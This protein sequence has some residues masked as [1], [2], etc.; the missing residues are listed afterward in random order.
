MKNMNKTKDKN[1]NKIKVEE[2][3]I[4]GITYVP[5]SEYK[6]ANKNND[7]LDFVCIRTYSAGVHCGYLESRDKKEVVLRDAIRI[8]EWKGAFTLSQLSM[9]GVSKPDGCKFSMP[10]DKIILTEGIEII[11]VSEKARIS[12]Q[13]VTSCK[14]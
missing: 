10:V 2:M 4:D 1:M 5:K 3:V 11:F 8:W 7:G 12:I 14:K 13:G 6:E 9:E